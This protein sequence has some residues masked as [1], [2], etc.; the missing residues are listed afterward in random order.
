[1]NK[2]F[3]KKLAQKKRALRLAAALMAVS[4][5]GAASSQVAKAQDQDYDQDDPPGRVARLG[6]M[7]GSVS[8]Q[9]AGENEWVQAVPNRPMTTGDKLWADKDA[10]AEIQLG[11]SMINLAPNTGFSFLNLDDRTVQMEVTAGAINLR[12]WSMD[13]DNVFEIDTPNQAFTVSEPGRYKIETSEN[14]DYSVVTIWQGA[15]ESTGNGQSYTLHA[16]Q[17]T[18]FS[19]TN[20]LNAEVQQIGNPDDFD[21]WAVSR[22]RRYDSSPS[23]R[24]CSREVVGFD[25]LD[26]NGDWQAQAQYGNVWYPRVNAGWAPYRD[27]HWAWIDPWGWTWVDDARWGYAPFHYGRWAF[28]SNRW[29]WIPGPVAVRPVYA[30]ALVVF[31]GGGGLAFGGNVA[32]FPLGPREVYV[33]SYQVSRGYVNRVNVSNTV[34]NQTT[35]TNVYNTTIINKNTTINNVT[36][37]NRTVNNAVT[38]VPQRTFVSAQ[39]VGRAA[40]R[41]NAQQIASAPMSSRA[42][43]PPAREAVL[44]P[45][46]NTA[47]RVAAPPQ[48]IANR[49]ITAKAAPPPPRPSFA[50]RQQVLDQHPGQPIARPAMQ[51]LAPANNPT[52]RLVKVA[53]PAKPA[54]AT[55]APANPAANR[56]GNAPAANERPGATPPTAQPNNRPQPNQPGPGSRPESNPPA[57]NRP[58]PNQPVPNNRPA[59]NAEP[60]RPGVPPARTD[61][62][63]SAQ[64]NNRPEPNQPAPNRPGTSNP[65]NNRPQPNRPETNQPA[66][67]NR[68]APKAEPNRPAEPPVRPDRPPSAQPNA[69]P[70]PNQPAPNAHPDNPRPDNNRPD[71]NRPQPNRPE[72]NQPSNRP[73]PNAEPNRQREPPARAE[74]PS[75]TPP[76]ARPAPQPTPNRPETNRPENNRPEAARP[77]EQPRSEPASRPEAAPRPP[78]QRPPAEARP[79][80]PQRQQQE[81]PPKQEERKNE[82]KKPQ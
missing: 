51:K 37:V 53:P 40:V 2:A 4:L 79:A 23:A 81:K 49:T 12:V 56:P 25:D 9:P 58:I 1:M 64:P 14:G 76:N 34:V 74:H 39:P 82:D 38:A 21:N 47:N 71:N 48:A 66:P 55:P 50:A 27:G 57:P 41:V 45:H 15:G 73:T 24:Y 10:R 61:H 26:E 3:W 80:P 17:R 68:P 18:T 8:F 11:S 42:A 46:A 54:T 72:A 31:V 35:I 16:G 22:E 75:S 69:R 43:V 36:Y 13:R 20:A 5:L 19:G 63:P 30:P 77:S 78:A 7:Q 59:P 52:A 33:P 60:N 6:Y 62:P 67:N 65:E 32:W 70:E 29:G 28:I 44:G